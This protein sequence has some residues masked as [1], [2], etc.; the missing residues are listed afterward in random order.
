[1]IQR[2]AKERLEDTDICLSV[3][4]LNAKPQPPTYVCVKAVSE[5]FLASNFDARLCV[6]WWHMQAHGLA[7]PGVLHGV[8][9]DAPRSTPLLV[10][11]FGV[12]GS[13]LRI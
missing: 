2:P 4:T 8:S 6:F 1:M 12:Y 3:S 9:V 10:D 13:G 5:S 7:L 11:R